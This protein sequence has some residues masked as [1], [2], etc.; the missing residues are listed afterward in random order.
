MSPSQK[1]PEEWGPIATIVSNVLPT[2]SLQSAGTGL[3][4]EFLLLDPNASSL[5]TD[6]MGVA[7]LYH[8]PNVNGEVENRRDQWRD[9]P[10]FFPL[11]L[12]WEGRYTHIP[13]ETWSLKDMAVDMKIPK[14]LRY[15]IDPE[16]D[17]SSMDLDHR[18]LSG[19]VL[20]LPQP[21]FS[22]KAKVEQLFDQTPEDILEKHLELEKRNTLRENLDKLALFLAPLSGLV[23]YLTTKTAGSHFKP[24]VRPPGEANMPI[25]GAPKATA[26]AKFKGDILKLI[27]DETHMTPYSTLA[28]PLDAEHTLFKPVTHGQFRFTKLNIIDKFGQVVHA[29]DPILN[30][31]PG[32]PVYPCLSEFYQP[33]VLK[34]NGQHKTSNTVVLSRQGR[35]NQGEGS[36]EAP[37]NEW[38]NPIWGWVLINYANL[39]LQFFLHDGSFYREVRFGGPKGTQTSPAWLPFQPLK[40]DPK[41]PIKGDPVKAAKMR[42]L[43]ILIGKMD[44]REYL[45][46]FV[47][48]ITDAMQNSPAAPTAYAEFLNAIISKPLALINMGLSLELAVDALKSES[49][50]EATPTK[51]PPVLLDGTDETQ[52]KFPVKIGDRERIFD[53]LVAYFHPEATP[54]AASQLNLDKFFTFSKEDFSSNKPGLDPD[55]TTTQADEKKKTKHR[56]AINAHPYPTLTPFWIPPMT[57]QATEK[58][59]D[60]PTWNADYVRQ[61]TL[62]RN[63]KLSVFGALIDPFLSIHLF[64]SILPITSLTLPPWTWQQ[65]MQKMA[66]F[67]HI[68]LLIVTE[69]VPDFDVKKQLSTDTYNNFDDPSLLVQTAPVGIPALQSGDWA[70]LQP[71]IDPQ[72]NKKVPKDELDGRAFMPLAMRPLDEKPRFEE[73]PC[74]ALEGYLQLRKP[75]VTPRVDGKK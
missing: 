6:Q 64:S 2:E 35:Q 36:L 67:F 41:D 22:L 29:I 68:G 43:D 18:L 61:H 69:N 26:D 73:G 54:T 14:K 74:T 49:L 52:Y 17:L 24:T 4:K 16:H 66:A 28:H 27:G 70:W 72:R 48:I 10:P 62:Q 60:T 34:E 40:V 23:D 21:N 5:L 8:D 57:E 71:Y 25:T 63:S 75:I 38:E 39:G 55:V 12:E 53:G 19:R 59:P 46:E 47:D 9:T 37:V 58:E 20:I 51:P 30:K 15:G 33:Q 50:S 13:Y 7:P 45:Q 31:D 44:D 56:E 1:L 3:L 11:C 32:K 65:A 42:Q